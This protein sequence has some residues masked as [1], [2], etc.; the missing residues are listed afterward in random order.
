MQK[1][2][3]NLYSSLSIPIN[4][5]GRMF[6]EKKSLLRTAYQ[7]DRDRIVHSTAFRRLKHND[8]ET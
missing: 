5:K 8:K 7:R 1:N 6:L 2:S 4:S 3:K